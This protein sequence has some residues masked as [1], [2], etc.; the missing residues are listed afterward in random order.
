MESGRSAPSKLAEIVYD[1]DISPSPAQSFDATDEDMAKMFVPAERFDVLD[2]NSAAVPESSHHYGEEDYKTHRVD[3]HGY[4]HMHQPMKTLKTHHHRHKHKG[5]KKHKP[6]EKA[7]DDDTQAVDETDRVGG[8]QEPDSAGDSRKRQTGQ[9]SDPQMPQAYSFSS[10]DDSEDVTTASPEGVLS[11]G[12]DTPL[13]FPAKTRGAVR[14]GSSTGSEKPAQYYLGGDAKLGADDVEEMKPLFSGPEDHGNEVR[15]SKEAVGMPLSPSTASFD[16]SKTNRRQSTDQGQVCFS[17]G[18][19]SQEDIPDAV[20]DG[21]TQPVYDHSKGRRHSKTDNAVSLEQRRCRG[22]EVMFRSE[23][24]AARM[25]AGDA[26]ETDEDDDIAHRYEVVRG[27]RRRKIKAKTSVASIIHP[28]RGEGVGKDETIV[29]VYTKKKYD[30]SPHEVFV[31]LDE[32]IVGEDNE[33]TWKETARWIKFEEDIQEA[34]DRWGKPHVPSLSFHSLLELRK[35][36]ELGTVLLDLEET[37][38]SGVATRVVD[39]MSTT[40]QIREEDRGAVLKALLLKHKRLNEAGFIRKN[41]SM[42]NLTS[43]DGRNGHYEFLPRGAS[44]GSML[45]K[46][47]HHGDTHSAYK[48]KENSV[49]VDIEQNQEKLVEKDLVHSASSP[50][51]GETEQEAA[52]SKQIAELRRKIPEGA[53]ASAILVG[54][55]DFLDKPTIAFV[56]LA[57]GT[58]IPQLTEI[59]IPTRFI[60]VLLGPVKGGLDYH[61]VGRS[62]ATLMSNKT[63]HTVAYQAD[64]RKDILVAINEFL[65]T[66]TVLPPGEWDKKTLLGIAEM[67]KEQM[68]KQAA[69]KRE[70]R[71]HPSAKEQGAA[72]KPEPSDALQRTGR[73]FG[74]VINDIKHRYP[75]YKGDL[76]DALNMQ[77]LATCI[78]IFFACLS[79]AITFGG[80]MNDRTDQW[81]GVSEMLAASALDG[82]IYS[83]FSCQPLLILGAT[84]PI[85][86][87]EYSLFSFCES[88]GYEFL[89]MR[90]WI[91][92]WVLIWTMLIVAFDGSVLVRYFTRFTEEIFATLISFIFIFGCFEKLY[93]IYSD[94]P[95]LSLEEY[96]DES[97]DNATMFANETAVNNETLSDNAT[98]LNSRLSQEPIK[99]QPN[100]A[101]MSTVFMLGTFFLANYLKNF[102]NSKFLGRSLRRALGDFGVPIA[103]AVMTAIDELVVTKTYTEKL[104]VPEGFSPTA[105][106]KRGWIINPLGIHIHFE[107]YLMF[108]ASIPSLMLYILVFMD[109]QISALIINKKDRCLK[110]GTGYHM[111]MFIVGIL[112]FLNGAFGLPWMCAATVRSVAHWSSLTVMSRTHAPGDKP[113]VVHVH[114]QRVTNFVVSILLGVCVLMGPVLNAVPEAVLFGIFLYMGISSLQGIQLVDRFKMLFKPGKHFPDVGY[115]KKVRTFKI[116][117]FTIIQILCMALLWIVKSSVAALAFPFVLLLMVAVRKAIEFIFDSA[118]LGELD[119]E[120]LDSAN[121]EEDELDFYE[122]VHVAI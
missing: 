50:K 57:E 12:S 11:T 13:A 34:A 25:F 75:M 93:H 85:L 24:M 77:C 71:H 94:H 105:P 97:L 26:E 65:D 120:D 73:L 39:N 66:S 107:W 19:E 56:R 1:D 30:H 44:I 20:G 8:A 6:G 122:Q 60:F 18:V 82:F 64:D 48:E 103:I 7:D 91:G 58:V 14:R 80:V 5:S 100:T 121:E 52:N 68:V 33:T 83:I 101:L 3:T 2:R 46:Y 112:T 61:E 63:F 69:R 96:C 113:K 51:L 32:L 41:L 54:A 55:V 36:L 15:G 16:D 74:G 86:V 108:A 87:F 29:P 106:E 4:P 81:M 102:R 38:L 35:C 95:L 104:Y 84:G 117:M 72:D 92:V 22:S 115:V 114:E 31:E 23:S 37:T 78:F 49:A 109:F 118:E 28:A 53:E 42:K 76:L 90:W 43:L 47:I 119:K 27:L 116:H 79:P 99:N 111:D 45:D 88:Q 40:D 10:H 59:D 17:L 21:S 98:D 62:I 89:V 9:V 110:K 70:R 67:Q